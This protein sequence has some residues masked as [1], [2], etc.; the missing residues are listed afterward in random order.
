[1]RSKEL[2]QQRWPA[3]LQEST[4]GQWHGRYQELEGVQLCARLLCSSDLQHQQQQQQQQSLEGQQSHATHACLST[5]PAE[6]RSQQQLG[7]PHATAG[8]VNPVVHLLLLLLLHAVLQAR[9]VVVD[10]EEGVIQ[11]MLKVRH[12]DWRCYAH[13]W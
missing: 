3:P 4:C 11:H 7:A 13:P 2:N 12:A 8:A 5:A 9:A 6:N 1:V 10:M